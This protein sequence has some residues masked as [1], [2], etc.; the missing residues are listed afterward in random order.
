M[1]SDDPGTP[2]FGQVVV[3]FKQTTSTNDVA[4]GLARQGA[5]E[6]TIVVTDEQTAGRGR[7]GHVWLSPPGA[8]L[9]FSLIFRPT[10][11]PKQA[12]LLTMVAAVAAVRAI[13]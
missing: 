9:L 5:S 1:R 2:R 8:S 11:G 3:Y 12:Y 13:R 7:R 10:F 6:G 4:T